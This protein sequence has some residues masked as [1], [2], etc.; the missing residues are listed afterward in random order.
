MRTRENLHFTCPGIGASFVCALPLLGAVGLLG[1]IRFC[2]RFR[3]LWACC[4]AGEHG[5]QVILRIYFIGMHKICWGIKN[6]IKFGGHGQNAEFRDP[7]VRCHLLSFRLC[8][9][10]P[11]RRIE[12]F[13]NLHRL[14]VRLC[15]YLL[16]VIT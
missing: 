12:P 7:G 15:A 6:Y 8:C 16:E 10:T 1:C 2:Y 11:V 9:A 3:S 14:I 13:S 5:H 4:I